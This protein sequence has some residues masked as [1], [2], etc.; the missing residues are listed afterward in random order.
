VDA[1]ER[2][3]YQEDGNA[4]SGEATGERREEMDSKRGTL[5]RKR[6]PGEAKVE[7]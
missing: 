2:L 5:S 1:K 3:E 4:C 7:D 6:S